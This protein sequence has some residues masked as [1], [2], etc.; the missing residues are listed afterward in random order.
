MNNNQ[1]NQNNNQGVFNQNPNNNQNYNQ[2]QMMQNMQSN[3]NNNQQMNNNQ[4]NQNNGQ[5]NN[6]QNENRNETKKSQNSVSPILT[7][8]IFIITAIAV[9][10]VFTGKINFDFLNNNSNDNINNSDNTTNNN[11]TDNNTNNSANN[12]SND[13]TN[14]DNYNFSVIQLGELKVS[15]PTNYL[16]E[17]SSTSQYRI[18]MSSDSVCSISIIAT[19]S[20]THSNTNA[21]IDSMLSGAASSSNGKLGSYKIISKNINNESWSYTTTTLTASGYNISE[22]VSGILKN[23]NY[24]AI[25]YQNMNNDKTCENFRQSI[26]KTIKFN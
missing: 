20:T 22:Y 21:M 5:F 11:I 25:Q 12:N 1:F 3:Y 18:Y 24:Y 8:I 26:E 4:Y 9:Y 2:Q 16:K 13:S 10:V 7:I 19:S 14:S 6:F 17:Y 15:I 23:N